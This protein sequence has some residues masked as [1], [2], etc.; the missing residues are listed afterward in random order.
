MKENLR[1][2]E[3]LCFKNFDMKYATMADSNRLFYDFP[4][5][6]FI[7]SFEPVET[8]IWRDKS[9]LILLDTLQNDFC[10]SYSFKLNENK[11]IRILFDLLGH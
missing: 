3:F 5:Q 1:I 10:S 7:V 8:W 2:I 9:N 11:F 4:W 6:T